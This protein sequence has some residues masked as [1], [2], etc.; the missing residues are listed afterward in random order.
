ELIEKQI[1]QHADFNQQHIENTNNQEKLFKDK[2]EE[3]EKDIVLMKS[4]YLVQIE[5]INLDYE[6]EK[7][8]LKNQ[9]QQ[10]LQAN[11]GNINT[12][13]SNSNV[14]Q[15]EYE[16][17]EAQY[18]IEKLEKQIVANTTKD[19]RSSLEGQ[20]NFLNDVIVELRNTNE[21]LIK[22]MEF[23]KNPF[24]GDDELTGNTNGRMKL[25]APRL[26]C[27]MCEVFD[28]HDAD[29][30]S[31]Q[32]SLLDKQLQT[33]HQTSGTGAGAGA[34]AGAGAGAGAADV[35]AAPALFTG[36]RLHGLSTSG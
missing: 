4:Q 27:S 26:C 31:K 34:A 21:R 15:L 29:D 35:G 10:A 7:L 24:A 3:N 12:S 20:I 11:S 32:S 5:N 23:Q 1:K 17:T 13:T 25:S 14:Q 2:T 6:Q 18:Q 8:R 33:D 16:V 36:G 30:C 22:E 19:D 28:Q 9:L